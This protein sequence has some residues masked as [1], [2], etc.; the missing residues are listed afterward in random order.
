MTKKARIGP[1]P[2]CGRRHSKQY[3]C[4][5]ELEAWEIEYELRQKEDYGG[6]VAHYEAVVEWESGGLNA[7]LELG[8][9]YVLNGEPEK[10]IDLLAEP[11]RQNPE[12]QELHYV[13]LDALFALGKDENDFDWVEQM[14]VQRLGAGVLDRCHAYLK[15]KRQPRD[16]E[17]LRFELS[18]DGY[19]VFTAGELLEAIHRDRRFVVEY[20]EFGQPEVRAR[21]KREGKARPRAAVK[22]GPDM[23]T[24]RR[25]R[26]VA[27]WAAAI[28]E[29][30]AMPVIPEPEADDPEL[31]RTRLYPMWGGE[32][33]YGEPQSREEEDRQDLECLDTASYWE[34]RDFEGLVAHYFDIL[35]RRPN[36]LAA[37]YG[38][39]RAY[40]ERGEADAVLEVV[41][42]AHRR[43]PRLLDFQ[44]LLLEALAALGRDESDFD[45]ASELRIVR[46]DVNAADL[47]HE[48][49]KRKRR[50]RYGS[51][52]ADLLS[53]AGCC[54][55]SGSELVAALSGDDRFVLEDGGVRRRRKRDGAP[56][57]PVRQAE[58]KARR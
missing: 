13:I 46:L 30:R 34:K 36:D 20:D 31:E 27:A 42:A 57:A 3:R 44:E 40:L 5:A 10:A 37:I 33:L 41:G 14:P 49:L 38:L 26:I 2:Y 48:Y 52:L 55:F 17:E 45:W 4:E 50:P 6:L 12:A 53:R 54:P 32:K 35:S 8:D 16:A 19:C 47:C 11:H 25:D 15:P 1:C 28:A 51:E 24:S 7:L 29:S 58:K 9:A 56:R 21:R 43:Y 22:S 18:L 39:G 23:W